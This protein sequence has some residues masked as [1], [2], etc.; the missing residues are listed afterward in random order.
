MKT[1]LAFLAQVLCATLVPAVSLALAAESCSI[2]RQGITLDGHLNCPTISYR[3]GT[4]YLLL[5]IVTSDALTPQRRPMN[6]S[7]VLDRS[8]SMADQGK[9]EYAKKALYSLIDQLT[10]EDMVSIVIYDDIINVLRE[11]HRVGNK[12]DLKKIVH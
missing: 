11:A 3:G 4:A 9:M 1:I 12:N 6:L 8:G 5:S 10:S 7:I 2:P